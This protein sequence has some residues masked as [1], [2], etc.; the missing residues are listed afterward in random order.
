MADDPDDQVVCLT[1]QG[2]LCLFLEFPLL[3]SLSLSILQNTLKLIRKASV[4]IKLHGVL[5]K[6]FGEMAILSIY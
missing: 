5:K 3:F 4:A 2:C 6:I 1:E